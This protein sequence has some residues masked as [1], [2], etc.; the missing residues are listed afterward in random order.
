MP[1]RT[2]EAQRE[3]QRNWMR[4]RRQAWLSANGPCV[5]CGSTERLEVDHRDYTEKVDHKV[6]SWSQSRRDV[7]LAKCVVRC[8]SCH[9]VKTNAEFAVRFAGE[10][11][12]GSVLTSQLVQQARASYATG[13]YTWRQLAEQLGVNPTT[14]RHACNDHWSEV[15]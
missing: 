9:R 11:N 7:E 1:M 12:P 4:K 13:A 15:A 14:L 5:D 2:R 6:W 3:Y 8:H 10:K